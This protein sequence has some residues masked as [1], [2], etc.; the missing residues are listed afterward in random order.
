M[1][2]DE[3]KKNLIF[4]KWSS[5]EATIFTENPV[6]Y[7]I[8]DFFTEI[9]KDPPYSNN[10]CF[11]I[12]KTV[13]GKQAKDFLCPSMVFF[14]IDFHFDNDSDKINE[15]KRFYQDTNVNTLQQFVDLLSK[16]KYI[17][18]AGLSKS[19]VGIRGF[20]NVQTSFYEESIENNLDYEVDVNKQIHIS[21]W[22]YLMNYL[23]NTYGIKLDRIYASKDKSA[24]KLSQVTYRYRLTGSFYN[25]NWEPLINNLC[26][27]TTKE[28]EISSSKEVFEPSFLN[29]LYNNNK[30]KFKETFEHYDGFNS[31]FYVL[32]NQSD[33]LIFNFY[34]ILN[35][36][37]SREGGFRK[38][39]HL[40]N[41]D[42][43]YKYVKSV[44][45]GTDLP[46]YSFFFKRGIYYDEILEEDEN[47]YYEI[48]S[49]KDILP[50]IS[51]SVYNRLPKMFYELTKEY[52]TQKKDFLL[53][54]MLSTVAIYFNKVYTRYWEGNIIY[55]NI[56]FMGIG[57]S[58]SG[59]STIR[60]SKIL[61]EP[62]R[63]AQRE[64]YKKLK[65]E[66]EELPEKEKKGVKKPKEIKFV[67]GGDGGRA[68]L[69][70]Y[71]ENNGE[72]VL[73]WDTEADSLSSNNKTDWG[74]MTPLIR[75][76][77]MNESFD[78]NRSIEDSIYINTPKVGVCTTGTYTQ[79][80]P[81]IGK[82]GIT[83]GTY[84]R[85]LMY[86]WWQDM[87]T[88]EDPHSNCDNSKYEKYGEM[89]FELWNKKL[90]NRKHEIFFDYTP[91]QK[92]KFKEIANEL[93]KS[94]IAINGKSSDSVLKKYLNF[95]KKVCMILT[96]IRYLEVNTGYDFI[97]N[98][99]NND[100][101]ELDIPDTIFP[102]NDDFYNSIEII[103][104]CLSH[105]MA[106]FRTLTK[107]DDGVE[108]IKN[109]REE[110]LEVLPAK[111]TRKEAQ[112]LGKKYSKSERHINRTLLGF[113][114]DNR[115]YHK[116]DDKDVFYKK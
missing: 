68:A 80:P 53:L 9:R 89:L 86:W 10:N 106:L 17:I 19:G 42:V 26:V 29:T 40:D 100:L 66:Y 102:I 18:S 27:I 110:Y 64:E 44:K 62:L 30:E 6:E 93:F 116:D 103:K 21:N 111:F 16:D 33:E 83:N 35:E 47:I 76:G 56:F 51:E 105:S 109:W 5:V 99:Q 8:D 48:E 88:F 92:I 45:S 73:F 2:K 98:K 94:C 25:E 14:D 50:I 12:N 60:K 96:M 82:D 112:E 52:E 114:K 79:I 67:L 75:A 38:Q 71:L 13:N 22:E 70:K 91:E 104:V 31:L 57:S 59:K 84:A 34:S 108:P 41:V 113:L 37:Y 3:I 115:I 69:I 85:I 1:T 95:S 7:E 78:K 58:S 36:L 46:L 97:T 55:P 24:K 87:P 20:A 49:K 77:V 32:R 15:L 72:Q 65:E 23:S 54:S 81:V 43:F 28:Y 4:Y 61:V 39:G 107:D 74:D 11:V 101:S 63:R 90:R